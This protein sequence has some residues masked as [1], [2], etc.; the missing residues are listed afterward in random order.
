MYD[1]SEEWLLLR[2]EELRSVYEIIGTDRRYG[3]KQSYGRFKALKD[4][5]NHM[6][7]LRRS[8]GSTTKFK[9]VEVMSHKISNL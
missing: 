9:Y 7:F 2:G 6:D 5:L 4:C 1:L 3:M 8:F